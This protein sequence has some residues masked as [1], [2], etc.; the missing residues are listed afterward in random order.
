MN[1][2]SK[3]QRNIYSEHCSELILLSHQ[4]LYSNI[5]VAVFPKKARIACVV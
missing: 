3:D 2:K 4:A 5:N 1:C